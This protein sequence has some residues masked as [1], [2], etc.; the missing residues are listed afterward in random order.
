MLARKVYNNDDITFFSVYQRLQSPCVIMCC[1]PHRFADRAARHY[2]TRAWQ[3]LK[4]GK[5]C[6]ILLVNPLY[7]TF[8]VFRFY[9]QAFGGLSCLSV[10][11]PVRP[12]VRLCLHTCI[13]LT[14]RLNTVPSL[15]Q[16]V[17]FYT[18]IYYANT[19]M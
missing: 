12:P 14:V 8:L 7:K 3:T 16:L 2:H 4:H 1:S 17:Y 6:F 13:Y 11:L 15:R 5:E 19:P 9:M 10:C 18:L